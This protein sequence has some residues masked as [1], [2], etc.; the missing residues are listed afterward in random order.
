M[1]GNS[2]FLFFIF[3]LKLKMINDNPVTTTYTNDKNIGYNIWENRTAPFSTGW[4][5]VL[6][7]ILREKPN[8]GYG[9]NNH[10]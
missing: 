9:C 7:Q 2:S 3:F 4:E 10:N 5:K 6:I 1:N 8:S